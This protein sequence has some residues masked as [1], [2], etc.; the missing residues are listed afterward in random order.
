MAKG[1]RLDHHVGRVNGGIVNSSPCLLADLLAT[2]PA[3]V[4]FN[5][6]VHQNHQFH[7]SY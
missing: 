6:E 7:L 4:R 3:T 1:T 2:T 5:A